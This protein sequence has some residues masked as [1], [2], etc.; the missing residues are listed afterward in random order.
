VRFSAPVI[1]PFD[2]RITSALKRT[3]REV[4]GDERVQPVI[5]KLALCRPRVIPQLRFELE[6]AALRHAGAAIVSFVAADL[7][8]FEL[9]RLEESFIDRA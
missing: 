9:Q 1:F 7:E 6:S 4:A 8:S 5:A 2:K 3:L